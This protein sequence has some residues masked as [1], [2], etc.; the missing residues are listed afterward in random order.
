MRVIQILLQTGSSSRLTRKTPISFL[1]GF[2]IDIQFKFKVSF[3]WLFTSGCIYAFIWLK[4]IK[5]F[6]MLTSLLNA[7]I[8]VVSLIFHPN[9]KCSS[10]VMSSKWSPVNQLQWLQLTYTRLKEWV[11]PITNFKPYEW[12]FEN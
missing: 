1:F 12:N 4:L 2:K 11:P 9:L 8:W 10:N 7:K 5:S 3:E 6:E